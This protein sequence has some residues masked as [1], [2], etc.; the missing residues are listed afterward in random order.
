MVEEQLAT[1][2]AEVCVSA[3]PSPWTTLPQGHHGRNVQMHEWEKGGG[4]LKTC[5]KHKS[6]VSYS[7]AG[8]CTIGNCRIKI[9]DLGVLIDAPLNMSWQCTLVAKEANGTLVCVRNSAASR[10]REV[11]IPQLL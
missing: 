9:K 7:H 8:N 4:L 10:T 11:I 5:L 2:P 1:A 3:I 6:E